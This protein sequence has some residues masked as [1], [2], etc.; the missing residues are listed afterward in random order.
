MLFSTK[1]RFLKKIIKTSQWCQQCLGC[2]KSHNTAYIV[3]IRAQAICREYKVFGPFGSKLLFLSN[4]GQQ[5]QQ[6]ASLKFCRHSFSPKANNI[7]NNLSSETACHFRRWCLYAKHFSKCKTWI[8][9]LCLTLSA[10][11]NSLALWSSRTPDGWIC[12]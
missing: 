6:I 2:F 1:W 7:K 3:C 5:M 10:I 11:K 12:A 8:A 9:G 4:G